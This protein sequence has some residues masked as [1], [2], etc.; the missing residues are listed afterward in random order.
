[1]TIIE[2]VKNIC[3]T[4]K[5][6]W[7]SSQRACFNAGLITGYVAP[8]CRRRGSRVYWGSLIGQ[9]SFLLGT[10]RT[11]VTAGLVLAIIAFVFA[12][13]GVVIVAF[14]INA[15]APNFGAKRTVRW[16]SK[17]RPTLHA[18]ARS[19]RAA[20]RTGPRRARRSHR[21]VWPLLL[22][23]GLQS[24][25]KFRRTRRGL[26]GS[27]RG[28][29]DCRDNSSSVPSVRL[30]GVGML[31]AGVAPACFVART[32]QRTSSSEIQLRQEPARLRCVSFPGAPRQRTVNLDSSHGYMGISEETLA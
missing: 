11:P 17:W 31:G 8:R 30:G 12:I 10:Y 25:M 16:R 3:L 23:L 9:G 5:T 24:L 14:V 26:H 6:E 27:R 32:P 18:R 19:R 15:L 20:N 1:M 4:P 22:Y 7:P 13:F 21:A 28:L 2:R 29:R